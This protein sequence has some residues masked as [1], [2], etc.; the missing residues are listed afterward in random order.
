M[1]KKHK[2]KQKKKEKDGDSQ[3]DNNQCMEDRTTRQSVS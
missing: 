1:K 3:L 2:Q